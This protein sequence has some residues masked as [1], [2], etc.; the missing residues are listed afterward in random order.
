MNTLCVRKLTDSLVEFAQGQRLFAGSSY[1]V[2]VDA[3]EF[4]ADTTSTATLV[5]QSGAVRHAS[6]TLVADPLRRGVRRSDPAAPLEIPA[7]SETASLD[8]CAELAGN[9][10][11]LVPVTVVGRAFGDVSPGA[12][13]WTVV[14]LGD[15]GLASVPLANLTQVKLSAA[16]AAVPLSL[17]P[18][19]GELDAYVVVTVPVTETPRFPFTGVLV[20]GAD[21]VWN[22]QDSLVLPA[23]RWIL[24]V[25][26]V[27]DV[28]CADLRAGRPAGTELDPDGA[29]VVGAEVNS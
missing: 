23:R 3:A 6:C 7:W 26:K 25:V 17:V 20:G 28:Y 14:D 1:D 27:A 19:E 13:R 8:L 11:F 22:H 2:C 24:H 5:L 21:P 18:P 4:R 12:G 9:T 10:V 15:I 29:A 16:P